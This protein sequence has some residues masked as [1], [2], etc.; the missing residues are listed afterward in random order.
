M[1]TSIALC[2]DV[3]AY[4]GLCCVGKSID[5]VAHPVEKLKK[6]VENGVA[7]TL[8]REN[9]MAT[10]LQEKLDLSKHKDLLQ[11]QVTQLATTKTEFSDRADKAKLD[12]SLQEKEV[13]RLQSELAERKAKSEEEGLVSK[14]GKEIFGF[15]QGMSRM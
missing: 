6:Q 9:M 11:S 3:F 5:S 2:T 10:L 1:S 7:K 13:Q 15:F 12:L 8:Q 14:V 4:H